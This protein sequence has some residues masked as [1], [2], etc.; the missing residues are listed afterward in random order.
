MAAMTHD[1]P[2]D[3]IREYRPR[4]NPVLARAI[5]DC[6]EPNRDKRCGSMEEFLQIIRGVEQIDR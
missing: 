6:I 1:Q 5:H 3:D 4:I 2:P